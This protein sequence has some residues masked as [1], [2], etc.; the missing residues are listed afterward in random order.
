L[1]FPSFFLLG[2]QGGVDPALVREAK[3]HFEKG[4]RVFLSEK[5]CLQV[6]NNARWIGYSLTIILA[7]DG[8]KGNE[9][10]KK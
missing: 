7:K 3:T 2:A 4:L 5:F 10:G 6:L 8:F 1:N 9:Y